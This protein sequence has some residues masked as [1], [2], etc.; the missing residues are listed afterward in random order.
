MS[1]A[2]TLAA[3]TRPHPNPRV[4]AL[5][6]DAAGMVVGR[7]AH[8]GPGRPHAEVVALGQAGLRAAGG[9]L[10]VTLEPCD[11]TGRTPPCTASILA[12]GVARVV[13]GAVDPDERV[14]GRGLARLRAGGLEV[15][16]GIAA[17]AVEAMDPAYFHQRRTGRPRLT[18]KAALTLDGQAGAADGTSQWIT[19]AE[20]RADGHRLRAEA[21]AVMVGAGT[22][23]VDD[24]RLTVRLPGYRGPQPRPVVVAGR[25]P[26]PAGA[27]L[28]ERAPVVLA[29]G[30]RDCPGEVV[31]VPGPD[32]V[33]LAAGLAALAGRGLLDLLVEGGPTLA[34]A[35]LRAGL[36]QRGVFYLG[37]RLGGGVGL[38]GIAGHFATLAAAREVELVS[39]ERLGP[40]LRVEFFVKEQ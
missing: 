17:A 37:A 4:G 39:A 19:S 9:T 31:V 1:E 20:A 25:R 16:S 32:G 8:E 34:G 21:D 2:I 12:A 18:L 38:P 14:S 15:H 35:L 5:V 33:D 28:W 13:V 26:L 11:H 10:V 27:R 24:P 6:L 3:P 23:A 7:A 30:E 22:L 40:D 36:V 29:P